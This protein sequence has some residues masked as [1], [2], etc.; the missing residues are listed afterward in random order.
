MGVQAASVQLM[1]PRLFSIMR[2][3]LAGLLALLIYVAGISQVR[4]TPLARG[5]ETMEVALPPQFQV[6]LA[7]GDRHLAANIEVFRALVLTIND[8]DRATLKVLSEVQRGASA[9]NPAHEDNYYIAQAILP[10]QGFVEPAQYIE[11]RA[12]DSRPWDFLPGFFYAFNRYYFEQKPHEA[13]E[14]LFRAADRLPKK[15]GVLEMAARWQERGEDT[16]LAIR[17]IRA[18]QESSRNQ[19]LKANLQARIDR[20]EGLIALRQAASAYVKRYGRA[21]ARLADL[22]ASGEM[23]RLPDDPLGLGY[24]LDASGQPILIKPKPKVVLQ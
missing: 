18:M 11:S 2:I 17:M 6:F 1:S 4:K 5:P 23:A 19:K 14:I 7:M 15:E 3:L 8:K 9:L 10:W 16:E 24:G 12:M 21:P 22:V 13:A 20:L